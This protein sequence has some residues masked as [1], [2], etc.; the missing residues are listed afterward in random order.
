M[1]NTEY[2][3]SLT[4]PHPLLIGMVSVEKIKKYIGE[5]VYAQPETYL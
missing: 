4:P 2:L 1:S 5:Q 3:C